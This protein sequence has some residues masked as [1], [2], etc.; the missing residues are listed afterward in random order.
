LNFISLFPPFNSGK[1]IRRF[2]Q[3][4][5]PPL[6]LVSCAGMKPAPPLR[7]LAVLGR[8]ADWPVAWSN[9][10]AG[11]WLGGGGHPWK[12]PFLLLGATALYAGGAFLNDAFDAESDRA[13]RP[14]RPLPAGKVAAQFVWRAGFGLLVA[15]IFLLLFCSQ[16]SAGAAIL[17]AVCA[18]LYNFSHQFFM[19]APWLLGACRFWL[20]VVAGAAGVWGLNGWPILAGAALAIYTAGLG[21]LARRKPNQR[22]LPLWPL[23]ALAAP[24]ALALA[25]NAGGY[26]VKAIWFAVIF[27]VW[28]FWSARK[29]F[30]GGGNSAIIAANLFAGIVLADWLAVG[31][32][33]PFWLGAVVFPGLFGL[34]KGLQK[35]APVG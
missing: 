4:F 14:D 25:M 11:W 33:M 12:L 1:K 29:I 21:H 22:P 15:G 6:F 26:R 30:S 9:A 2:N 10:L 35:F 18:L 31:P 8:V 23:A 13:R 3:A 7:T 27:A 32:V 19:A 5:Q 34:T 20:Y 24:V 17:L 28:T 16:L